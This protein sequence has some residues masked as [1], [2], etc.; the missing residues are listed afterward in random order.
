MLFRSI[1]EAA[2]ADRNAATEWTVMQA[3]TLLAGSL[4]TGVAY[5]TWNYTVPNT[6]QYDLRVRIDP[7]NLIDE[8]SEI[9]N[10]HCM[11]VTGADVSSPGLVPS[12]APTMITLLCAGFVVAWLQQRD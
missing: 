2:P 7:S 3:E 1:L 8:N 12:F 4:G 6:G 11:V 5:L 10:D 9:N